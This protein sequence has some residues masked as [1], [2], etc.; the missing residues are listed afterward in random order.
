[1]TPAKE[2]IIVELD[3]PRPE[4]TQRCSKSQHQK[5][6]AI[7]GTALASEYLLRKDWLRPKEEEAWN[8]L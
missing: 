5:D 7:S 4:N 8:D 3:D 2:E 6:G 1:M